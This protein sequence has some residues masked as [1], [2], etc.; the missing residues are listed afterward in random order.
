[1][2]SALLDVREAHARELLQEVADA[3]QV[4]EYANQSAA[5]PGDFAE[6]YFNTIL[7]ATRDLGRIVSV[8]RREQ[9]LS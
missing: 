3:V 7:M 5:G 4:L 6:W 2:A 9:L 1:M 8:A